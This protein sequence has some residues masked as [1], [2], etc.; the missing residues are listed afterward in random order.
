MESKRLPKTY[1]R[2][3]CLSKLDDAKINDLKIYLGLSSGPKTFCISPEK[4]DMSICFWAAQQT[5]SR[6]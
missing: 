6:Y 4:S 3:Y 1:E 5:E 2:L